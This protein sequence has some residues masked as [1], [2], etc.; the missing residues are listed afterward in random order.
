MAQKASA[1]FFVRALK[2]EVALFISIPFLISSFLD[3]R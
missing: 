3:M 2:S 1:P